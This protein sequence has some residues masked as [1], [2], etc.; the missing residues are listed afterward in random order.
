MVKPLICDTNDF[1]ISNI[2]ILILRRK[3]SVDMDLV[4]KVETDS[5]M[6]GTFKENS[7]EIFFHAFY[8]NSQDKIPLLKL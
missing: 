5:R 6:L 1:N 8:S 3:L 7:T 4:G 2:Y